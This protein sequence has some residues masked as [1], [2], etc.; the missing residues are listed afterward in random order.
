MFLLEDRMNLRSKNYFLIKSTSYE[1][2][3]AFSP[4]LLVKKKGNHVTRRDRLLDRKTVRI[5]RI[6]VRA[7]SQTKGLERGWLKTESETGERS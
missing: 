1:Y 4:N 7:N 6:Q 2:W 5:L 3:S